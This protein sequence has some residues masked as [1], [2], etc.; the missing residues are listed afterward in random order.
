MSY[1]LK[2]H[3]YNLIWKI[4]GKPEFPPKSFKPRIYPK[5]YS[6]FSIETQKE[7][8]K[9]PLD[10]PKSY[11]MAINYT[12]GVDPY[13][14]AYYQGLDIDEVKAWLWKEYKRANIKD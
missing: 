9:R 5:F 3:I 13:K 1:K 2:Y 7:I 10:I 14:M 11:F 6:V 8:F 4:T 12:K